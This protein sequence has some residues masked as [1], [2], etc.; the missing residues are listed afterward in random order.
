MSEKTYK[1]YEVD[2]PIIGFMGIHLR[3]TNTQEA[4][5]TAGI[6]AIGMEDESSQM[7]IPNLCSWGIDRTTEP[8]IIEKGEVDG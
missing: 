3:A 1:L 2:V 8:I 7:I 4:L 5:S 6:I